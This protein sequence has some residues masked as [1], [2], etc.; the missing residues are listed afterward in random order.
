MKQVSKLIPQGQ[1]L[2][3]VLLRDQDPGMPA[4]L[5][6]YVSGDALN[7]GSLRGVLGKTLGVPLFHRMEDLPGLLGLDG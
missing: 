1:G 2:A 4:R 5:V 7:A 6:A 3:E